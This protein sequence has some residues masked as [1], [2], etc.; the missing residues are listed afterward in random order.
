MENWWNCKIFVSYKFEHCFIDLVLGDFGVSIYRRFQTTS[1]GPQ[2][3]FVAHVAGAL[4]GMTMGVIVL[5]NFKK[6]LRDKII[7]WIA[8]GVYI[9]FMIFA[10][11]WNIFWPYYN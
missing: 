8:I 6:S 10:V 3:S 1:T 9:A 4:A 11:F 7:F 5:Q 2:V